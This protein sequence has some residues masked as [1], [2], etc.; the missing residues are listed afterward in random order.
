MIEVL[1]RGERYLVTQ[2]GHELCEVTTIW[3][4]DNMDRL[5]QLDHELSRKRAEHIAKAL[6][7]Y[8]ASQEGERA[9]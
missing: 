4:R 1:K 8:Q 3:K 7:H 6:R 5:S 2:N 9:P